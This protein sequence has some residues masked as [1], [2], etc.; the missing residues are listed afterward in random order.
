MVLELKP[1]AG[2]YVLNGVEYP[3]L[4]YKHKDMYSS[5]RAL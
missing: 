3:K 1:R 5:K 4:T 2:T